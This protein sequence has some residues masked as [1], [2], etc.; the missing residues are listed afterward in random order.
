MR[1]KKKSLILGIILVVF[2]LGIGY[3]Y[4]T[5]TLS[6]NGTTD[7]DSNTWSVYWDNVQVS[8]GSVTG[9]QVI[10]APT[11]SNQTTVSFHVRLKEPGE[12]YEFTVDAVNDGTLD[13]MINNVV[14]NNI[15]EY[16]EYTFAYEDNTPLMQNQILRANSSEK[17]KIK[18]KYKDN[19]YSP[20]D[21]PSTDQSISFAF[22]VEYVQADSNAKDKP[23]RVM[24]VGLDG[25]NI[26][27]S[28]APLYYDQGMTWSDLIQSNYNSY[29]HVSYEEG[30]G[31]VMDYQRYAC[32]NN[33]YSAEY[34][35]ILDGIGG[36]N[37]AL[38]DLI[39]NSDY[40]TVGMGGAC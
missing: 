31:L 4:L 1:N 21:L 6:I 36:N 8:A 28:E 24:L 23:R 37:P 11:I 19:I 9:T 14:V 26:P 25:N 13:A 27:V 10:Q 16:L 5:T 3:A 20:D 40:Y 38:N 32:G 35:L 7:V 12:Y 39:G 2:L 30:V 15:S 18:V 17:Y 29:Y 34:S 33:F 22:G